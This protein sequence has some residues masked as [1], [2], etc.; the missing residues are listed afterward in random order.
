MVRKR[1]ISI[2]VDEDPLALGDA[3]IFKNSRLGRII[4]VIDQKPKKVKKVRK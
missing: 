1:K 4:I 2:T 3:M